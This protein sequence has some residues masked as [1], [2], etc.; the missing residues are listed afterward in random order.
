M[1]T[2]FVTI[3]GLSE[4]QKQEQ[5]FAYQRTIQQAFQSVS[6]A[7]IGL[8]KYREFREQE[9]NLTASAEDAARLA[10]R[11]MCQSS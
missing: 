11:F 10:G 1:E 9:A 5:V 4:A 3:S 8:Q 2:G 7:L 6:D